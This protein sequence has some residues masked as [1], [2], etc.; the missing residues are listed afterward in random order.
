M[1]GNGHRRRP[2]QRVGLPSASLTFGV[3]GNVATKMGPLGPSQASGVSRL[4]DRGL[5]NQRNPLWQGV[6]GG[7]D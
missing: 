3:F 5:P 2:G 4:A 7:A 1:A 6:K